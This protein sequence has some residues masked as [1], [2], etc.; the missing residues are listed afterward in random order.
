MKITEINE[1]I[2]L[3]NINNHKQDL[4]L[5]MCNSIL[6]IYG[7]IINRKFPTLT[8]I[9]AFELLIKK[10]GSPIF[11]LFS[12]CYHII[13]HIGSPN[14]LPQFLNRVATKMKK[15]TQPGYRDT[16]EF[17]GVCSFRWDWKG[18]TLNPQELQA[19]K[20]YLNTGSNSN[21]TITKFKDVTISGKLKKSGVFAPWS[22][23]G[24]LVNKFSITLV[25][26]NNSTTYFDYYTSIIDFK[27]GK[28]ELTSSDLLNAL[29]C[30]LSDAT[31]GDMNFQDFCDEFGYDTDSIKAEKTHKECIESKI[32]AEEVFDNIYDALNDLNEAENM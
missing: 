12:K 25:N 11:R 22:T 13:Y 24:N 19:L 6:S 5:N 1:V 16:G 9:D 30:F 15:Q 18:Y 8:N 17:L 29:A 32:K 3:A 28:T 10:E 4:F 27:A 2:E 7:N 21:Q 20:I 26:S 31:S 23:E 14:S